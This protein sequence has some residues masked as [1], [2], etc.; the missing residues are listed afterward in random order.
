M[1]D[2]V[3]NELDDCVAFKLCEAAKAEITCTKHELDYHLV[4]FVNKNEGECISY[5]GRVLF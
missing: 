3:F 1:L 5:P 4:D 2:G